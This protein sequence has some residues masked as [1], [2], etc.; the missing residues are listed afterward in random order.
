LLVA[1]E[2]DVVTGFTENRRYRIGNVLV[3]L[4]R[5]HG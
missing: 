1:S 5:G 2:R 3:E 4:D